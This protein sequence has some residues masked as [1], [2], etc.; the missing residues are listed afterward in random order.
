MSVV[1]VDGCKRG[2]IAVALDS[3]NRARACF[4]TRLD[5]LLV[6]IPDTEAVAIDIPI[7]LPSTGRR[8]ADEAARELLGARRNSVFSAPVRAAITASNHAEASAISKRITGQGI[9][10]QAFA[11]TSKIL[12]AERWVDDVPVPVWEV[13]PEVCFTF[14][15]GHPA[16]WPKST[17][18]GMRERQSALGQTGISLRDIGEAGHMAGVDDVL[19]AAVAAWSAARLHCGTAISLPDPP[20]HDPHSQLSM[21][22]WA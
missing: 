4:V 10:R 8:R 16:R 13:H 9:S 5:D 17:W 20:E 22:I 14:M 21:A 11:L 18:S 15:M 1:G 2:W 19:D 12:E 6:A 3:M 7:G